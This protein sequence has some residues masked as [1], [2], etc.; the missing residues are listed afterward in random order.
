MIGITEQFY[1]SIALFRVLFGIQLSQVAERRNVNP[2]QNGLSYEVAPEARKAIEKYRSQ[3]IE[4]YKKAK[5]RF[6]DL[7]QR[8]GV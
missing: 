5:E 4:L 7:R 6:L 3:D 8:H 2:A 1:E